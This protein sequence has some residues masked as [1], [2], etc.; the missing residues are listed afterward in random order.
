MQED[1][2]ISKLIQTQ[3]LCFIPFDTI[4][5]IDEVL[6]NYNKLCDLQHNEII[7]M[8]NECLEIDYLSKVIFSKILEIDLFKTNRGKF[9]LINTNTGNIYFLNKNSYG[10]IPELIENFDKGMNLSSK[11]YKLLMK[12]SGRFKLPSE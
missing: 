8:E 9:R 3:K 11:D 7:C 4:L 5:S 6:L 1:V 12:N 2:L 10:L